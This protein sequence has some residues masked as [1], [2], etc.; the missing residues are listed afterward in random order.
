MTLEGTLLRVLLTFP[1][2]GQIFNPQQYPLVALVI[3]S[4]WCINR[5]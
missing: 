3:A 4:L 1:L 5:M 2:L